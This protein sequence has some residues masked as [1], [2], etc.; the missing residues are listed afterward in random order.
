MRKHGIKVV[1]GSWGGPCIEPHIFV[2]QLLNAFILNG[3]KAGMASLTG[4][5]L[6]DERPAI[7]Q[8]STSCLAHLLRTAFRVNSGYPTA[9]L[10]NP[11]PRFA[12]GTGINPPGMIDR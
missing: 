11:S 10:G 9:L 7:I 6:Y 8:R 2:N 3:H 1:E 4:S 5:G 12:I